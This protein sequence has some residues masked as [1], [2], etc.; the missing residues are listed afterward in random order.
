M[1]AFACLFCMSVLTD[2]DCPFLHISFSDY[3]IITRLNDVLRAGAKGAQE[4]EGVKHISRGTRTVG[5]GAPAH[6]GNGAGLGKE[7]DDVILGGAEG[8]ILD[9]HRLALVLDHIR[10]AQAGRC[11]AAL[12]A[13]VLLPPPRLRARPPI[14]IPIKQV[15]SR[16][17]CM[18][19][20][21]SP[22]PIA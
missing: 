8:Q 7:G 13:L 4:M 9:V 15:S 10:P 1:M 6:V 2:P 3:Q 19:Q 22:T 5:F 14:K 16:S 20:F 18:Q 17:K 21:Q 11:I 12:A